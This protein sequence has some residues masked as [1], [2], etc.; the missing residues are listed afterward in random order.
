MIEK[1]IRGKDQLKIELDIEC[2]LVGTRGMLA[3]VTLNYESPS[4]PTQFGEP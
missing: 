3:E 1:G 4:L 2:V